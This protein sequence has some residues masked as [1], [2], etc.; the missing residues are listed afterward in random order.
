[1][2]KKALI[3]YAT[4]V[5]ERL[6]YILGWICQSHWGIT[7]ILTDDVSLFAHSSAFRINYSAQELSFADLQIIPQGLLH[8]KDIHEQSINMGEWQNNPI[9]F[10]TS[11]KEIPFDIFSASFY[12]LSRYEEYLETK[13]DAFGRFPMQKSL[14]YRQQFL[15]KALIDRWLLA[16]K[17]IIQ[18]K[19]TSIAFITPQAKWIPTY[20]IDIA[21]SY[22]GKGWL[23]NGVGFLRDAIR[24]KWDDCAERW[25]VLRGRQKD[26]FDAYAQLDEWHIQYHLA[27]IY[28]FLLGKR[29]KY[30]KNLAPQQ[31][32]MQQL[33]KN[34]MSK[35]EVGIHP[36][37]R[38]HAHINILQ[39]ELRHLP[40]H[41]SRQHYIKFSLPKT[42]RT[43]IASGIEEDYSM[44][45]GSGNGFR[46]STCF[47]HPWFDLKRN[48]ISNL[49]LI[50]FCYMECNSRFEQQYNSD[51]AFNEMMHYWNEVSS[52][53]GT[54]VSIWHNFSL[55][56][57]KSWTDWAA[58]Y[59]RFLNEVVPLIPIN[60]EA[61][62]D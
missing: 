31:P 60:R 35:Y 37:Y 20:D 30:D 13:A 7:Y 32:L 52:V 33:I 53:G 56:T 9:F 5:S 40:T 27:P 58:V 19:E 45:Y 36:S 59:Q 1:M 47:A 49:Q 29:G 39:Q 21:Y 3:F 42:F 57:S 6:R 8:E 22:R 4:E 48:E 34:T 23:R 26:P 51:Q 28:F 62:N 15:D 43:L 17:K 14:A 25:A 18:Q 12:L 2:E 16:M 41:K 10:K 55:G 46:A 38:S 11:A 54:L 24:G 44:G 50:P 61:I